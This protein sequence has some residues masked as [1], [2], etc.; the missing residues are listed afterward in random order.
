MGIRQGANM[1]LDA[2]PA[3][4][5]V[6]ALRLLSE[7]GA[8]TRGMVYIPAGKRPRIGVHI[9]HPRADQTVNYTIP[10]LV[11]AGFMALGRAG[12]YVHND[13]AGSQEKLL[14]DY[15]AGVRLLRARGC[16]V[17]LLLGNSGG[18]A[19]ACYYQSQ[20]RRPLGTRF[21]DTPAGDPFDLNAFDLPP[22]DGIMKIGSHNGEGHMLSKWLDPSVVDE[23]DPYTAD[24]ELD[25]YHP[26][27]GFRIPPEPSNYSADFLQRFYAAKQ[28]RARRL[29]ALARERIHQRR[30]AAALAQGTGTDA[31]VRDNARRAAQPAHLLIYRTLA[32]PAFVDP[33]IEPDDRAVCSFNNEPRPDLG[34]YAAS[35]APFLTPDAYLSTWSGLSSR[36]NAAAR[37]PDIPDPLLIVHWG[38]DSNTRRSELNMMFEASAA[39]IKDIVIVPGADHFGFRI[40]GPGERGERP[41]EG[42]EALTAWAKRRFS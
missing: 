36:A 23:S 40:L 4:V 2:L 6:E 9:M 21:T 37:L 15:A 33:S 20:A 19:L 39:V 32:D 16:E 22:A 30:A 10:A 1:G 26:G 27:N 31:R 8:I 11:D 29:D 25:M 38:G 34:N 14:L 18:G 12:R 7:D 17:V 41:P 5:S 42:L 13:V 3:G 28:A 35:V 24:P